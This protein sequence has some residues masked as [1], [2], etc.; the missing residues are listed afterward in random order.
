VEGTPLN[1]KK[2]INFDDTK[3]QSETVKAGTFKELDAEFF[4]SLNDF[5]SDFLFTK[6]ESILAKP[7]NVYRQVSR[8]HHNLIFLDFRC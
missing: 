1:D 7:P 2:E 6:T 3:R 8:P 4:S 5:K